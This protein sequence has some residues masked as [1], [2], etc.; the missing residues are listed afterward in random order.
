MRTN[1]ALIAL[2]KS[3][4]PS[5]HPFNEGDWC[6]FQGCDSED[7]WIVGVGDGDDGYIIIA[8]GNTLDVQHAPMTGEPDD[9]GRSFTAEVNV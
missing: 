1:P 7:P 8:D 9:T 4:H 2:L 6:A 5:A 3:I